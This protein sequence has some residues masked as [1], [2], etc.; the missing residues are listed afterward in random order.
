MLVAFLT[1]KIL[2]IFGPPL[3]LPKMVNDPASFA[4]RAARMYEWEKFVSLY[5]ALYAGVSGL[6]AQST[7]MATV[8]DNITN[9]N[10]IGYKGT[11]AQFGTLVTNSGSANSYSAGGVMAKPQAMISAQGLLQSSGSLTDLGIDGAGFFVVRD[12]NAPNGNVAYTRAGSFAPDKQGFLVNA[13]GYYLQ[14]WPIDQNGNYS[15]NGS[16]SDLKPVDINGLSGAAQAST[17]IELRANLQ[18]TQPIVT[19]YAAGS[20]ANGTAT[21]QFSRSVQVYDAQ[22]NAHPVTFG[23]TKTGTNSWT[24]EIYSSDLTPALIK[25]GT[26]AFNGDGSLNA[27]GSTPTLFDDL[28]INWGNGASSSPISVS[29]GSDGKLDGLSQF[30]TESALLSSTVNGGVLGAVT[31]VNIAE[32]GMVSAVFEDG[33]MRAIYQLPIA[34]FQNA[35]GLSA[36][37]GN[38]YIASQESGSVAVNRAG[39]LGSG[40]ISAGTLEAS[41]V[42]LAGEFTNMIRFQRAYSSASKIITTVDDMLQELSNLKR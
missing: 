41:T 22:G 30:T 12:S 23:F 35:N 15:D 24:T 32:N 21:P 6:G 39:A 38:A 28:V 37:S 5:S 2:P 3:R 20:M 31:N 9:V 8:A 42:D 10:T 7:A 19:P 17:K 33:S 40:G 16:L 26:I 25:Q 11:S 27:A 4:R 18:S 13:N 36:I 1:R 29:L 14:G 34:T